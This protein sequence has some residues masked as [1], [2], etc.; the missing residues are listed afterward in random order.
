MRDSSHARN[1]Q[2]GSGPECTEDKPH[3]Y[4]KVHNLNRSVFGLHIL[5]IRAIR[6]GVDGVQTSQPVVGGAVTEPASLPFAEVNN[7]K[8]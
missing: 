4:G 1:P 6:E 8:N 7:D 2:P 5:W 3:I